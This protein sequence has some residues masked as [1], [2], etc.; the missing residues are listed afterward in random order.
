[1]EI[2]KAKALNKTLQI[3]IMAKIREYE[4]QTGLRITKATM[5]EFAGTRYFTTT[6]FMPPKTTRQEEQ[7]R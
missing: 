5:T 2:E 4:K 7:K 1:M 3:D 6:V